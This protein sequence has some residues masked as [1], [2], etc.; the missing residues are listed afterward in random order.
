VSADIRLIFPSLHDTFHCVNATNHSV[1]CECKETFIDFV[2]YMVRVNTRTYTPT[3]LSLMGRTGTGQVGDD[4]AL[5]AHCGHHRAR[6]RRLRDPHLRV[7]LRRAT[8]RFH[9]SPF[10]LCFLAFR[11]S[12]FG[13]VL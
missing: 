10:A 13:F 12:F 11:S 6:A 1:P 8:V 7:R 9:P 5:V 2:V 3:S 4:R